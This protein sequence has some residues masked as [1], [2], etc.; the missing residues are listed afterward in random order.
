MNSESVLP[1]LESEYPLASDQIAAFQRDGHVLLR[2]VCSPE[3][4][5]AYRPAIVDATYRFSHETRPLEERDTYGKAFIQT[6][7]LCWRDD[8]ARRFVFARRFAQIGAR[9]MR[10]EAVRLY[11]DQALFKEAGG[12]PTPWHQDQ[13]YWPLDTDNTVTMWMPLVDLSEEMGT[14]IF[15]TGSHKK[16]LLGHLSISDE[17][18]EEYQRYVEESRLPQAAAGAMRAGD[19][20][21]HAGLTLHRAP[22][23]R[24]TETREAMT[25]I[26][27][28][29]GVRLLEPD[30]PGREGDRRAIFPEGKAGDLA[31]SAITPLLYP[32]I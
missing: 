7:G 9:L 24:G 18:E 30:N 11:H 8:T 32:V 16:G 17:S 28:P 14:M 21:F 4:V 31:V 2:G 12:G 23:N 3:E 15:A 13:Y 26:Y 6:G 25:V 22:G 19:A 10:V 29:E 20:T 27:Y 5:A 1:P